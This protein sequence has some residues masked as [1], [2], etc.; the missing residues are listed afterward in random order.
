M[1]FKNPKKTEAGVLSLNLPEDYA[2][3]APFSGGRASILSDIKGEF[4]FWFPTDLLC[5]LGLIPSTQ[6]EDLGSN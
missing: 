2:G 3:D 4:R 6:I 5:D 1:D